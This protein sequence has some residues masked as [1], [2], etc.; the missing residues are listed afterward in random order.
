VVK[1]LEGV[2]FTI[3]GMTLGTP[4]YMS[5]EQASGEEVTPASDIYALGVVVYEMLVG[6]LPFSADTPLAV[7]LM[8]MSDEPTLPRTIVPDL[9]PQVDDVI[10]QA[11]AK[12]PR[13]RFKTAGEMALALEAVL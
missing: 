8:H 12:S 9:P 7:L 10:S 4:D 5:P 3:T 2:Q 11:L 13:N 6:Q 1:M